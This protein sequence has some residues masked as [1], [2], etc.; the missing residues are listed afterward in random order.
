LWSGRLDRYE[1]LNS[2]LDQL[3]RPWPAALLAPVAPA[4]PDNDQVQ[5]PDE[6]LES[7]NTVESDSAEL[8]S[9]V[10]RLLAK[11]NSVISARSA[12]ASSEQRSDKEKKATTAAKTSTSKSSS[13]GSNVAKKPAQKGPPVPAVKPALT[14][15]K[16]VPKK[17]PGPSYKPAH[18]TAPFRTDP[19]LHRR[20]AVNQQ[21]RAAGRSKARAQAAADA[22][23][24]ARPARLVGQ[25][26]GGDD[27]SA[28]GRISKS[29]EA[30]SSTLASNPAPPQLAP[31]LPSN[32]R[33]SLSADFPLPPLLNSSNKNSASNPTASSSQA[34]SEPTSV[35]LSSVPIPESISVAVETNRR[36]RRRLRLAVSNGRFS[37]SS[38]SSRAESSFLDKFS[39]ATKRMSSSSSETIGTKPRTVVAMAKLLDSLLAEYHLQEESTGSDAN[40]RLLAKIRSLYVLLKSKKIL[41]DT[42]NNNSGNE[43]ISVKT[44]LSNS[45]FCLANMPD[46][47]PFA[48]KR[49]LTLSAELPALVVQADLSELLLTS[50]KSNVELYRRITSDPVALRQLWALAGGGGGGSADSRSSWFAGRQPHL[51]VTIST[52]P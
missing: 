34:P 50:W 4:T 21:Y 42:N 18:V 47:F 41:Y 15:T 11:A 43:K 7:G 52:V 3:L 37:S 39:L 1:R 36:L 10:D 46:L 35:P 12:S 26:L 24:A 8:V 9:E 51:P 20:V 38:P 45:A 13:A 29:A 22:A 30:Q 40:L 14:S 48:S 19:K 6:A 23:E 16:A 49:C 33:R 31:V 27:K 25:W 32:G 2:Q 44:G 5:V 28:T 17:P